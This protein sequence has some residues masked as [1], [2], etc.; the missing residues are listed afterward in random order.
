MYMSTALKS[1]IP[2]QI[3]SKTRPCKINWLVKLTIFSTLFIHC[4]QDTSAHQSPV[5]SANLQ[6]S[7]K[8]LCQKMLHNNSST[9]ELHLSGLFGTT[10]HPYMK[11]IQI[12]YFSLKTGYIGSVKFS[13]YYLKYLPAFKPFD[14]AWLEVLEAITLYCTWSDN[15]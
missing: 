6:H 14:H 10:S 12:I 4:L 11:K 13:C 1:H 2:L 3:C 7:E 5:W 8:L 15:W 9:V